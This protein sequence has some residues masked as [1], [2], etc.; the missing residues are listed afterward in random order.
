MRKEHGEES[1]AAAHIDN[2]VGNVRLVSL[3]HVVKEFHHLTDNERALVQFL[4]QSP[5]QTIPERRVGTG[6][7]VVPELDD[8]A[9]FF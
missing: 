3:P 2:R 9:A 5:A 8:G 6:E 7:G 4:G 1:D